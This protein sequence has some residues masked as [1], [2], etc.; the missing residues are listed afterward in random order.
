VPGDRV[1]RADVGEPGQRQDDLAA[2]RDLPAH[3]PGVAALRHDGDAGRGAGTQRRRDLLAARRPHDGGGGPAEAPG[4]VALVARGELP[5][6]EHLAAPT[7]P[8][9][10]DRSASST[11][12]ALH[13]AATGARSSTAMNARDHSGMSGQP[14]Q[15]TM[16]PS[17]TSGASTTV[18]PAFSMSPVSGGNAAVRRPW[19]SP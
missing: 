8:A 5:A 3:E 11:L 18:A 13:Y 6:G 9:S 1:E 2:A 12:V 15:E 17:T 16:L 10:C 14:R 19:S 4:E 7:M